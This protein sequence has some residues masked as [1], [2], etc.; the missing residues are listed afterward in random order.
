MLTLIGLGLRDGKDIS[1]R[2]QELVRE[3]SAVFLE[4]Y[5]SLLACSVAELEQQLGVS[6][7]VLSREDVEQRIEPILERARQENV[8]L[9]IIGD[10]FAATT[11]DDMV[12]RAYR[13]GA[14]V[15]ILHNASIISAI[16]ETGLE[17]Y[18]FGKTVSIPYWLPGY[19]PT[20][21]LASI[22]GNR[23]RGLHT[24]C[25]LDIK[26][27]EQRFMSVH[28]GIEHLRKA[29]EKT[30]IVVS[31]GTLV[32]VA[33]LGFADSLIVAGSADELLSVA[34]GGPP[35]CLV[36]PGKVTDMEETFLKYH[37]KGVK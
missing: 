14:P 2:G 30:D 19:E 9:L 28:E 8:V 10:P 29:E 18:R 13:I 34:F 20:S 12:S 37:S 16:G 5:T 25:L 24:L 31:A 7:A 32:G 17:L 26:A 27:E 15:Q 35:H 11:H 23:S 33:R 4:G 1:V 3:A 22:Q 6:I 21:F 36:I